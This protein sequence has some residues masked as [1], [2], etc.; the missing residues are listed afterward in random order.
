MR[1]SLGRRVFVT[2]KLI[3]VLDR[4]D[5]TPTVARPPGRR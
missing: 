5:P 1:V 2:P 3:E 4:L